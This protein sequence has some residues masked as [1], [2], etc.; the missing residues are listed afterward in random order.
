[1]TAAFSDELETEDAI[2]GEIH[3]GGED[4][5]IRAMHLLAG[6]VLLKRT[7]PRLVVLESDEAIGGEGTGEDG[8]KSEGG[9]ERLVQDIAHLVLEILSRNK[10]IE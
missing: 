10:R 3:V 5:C 9:L 7:I 6:E 2:F 4:A 8:D 1:M